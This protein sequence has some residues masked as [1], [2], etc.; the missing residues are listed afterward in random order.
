M[1]EDRRS[2]MRQGNGGKCEAETVQKM[3]RTE[4]LYGMKT[5]AA[6]MAVKR[7]QETKMQVT[8]MK[9]DNAMSR[10]MWRRVIYTSGLIIS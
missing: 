2:D 3:M 8:R 10:K 1:E 7:V 4:M 9:E 6:W 5:M